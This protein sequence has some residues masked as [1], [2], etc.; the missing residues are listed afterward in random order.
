MEE[1]ET[2]ICYV[3]ASVLVYTVV[4]AEETFVHQV[5]AHSAID[6]SLL[7][8]EEIVVG[9]IL[10]V[11]SVESSQCVALFK[12]RWVQDV[13]LLLAVCSIIEWDEVELYL[14]ELIIS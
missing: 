14:S 9:L 5:L 2:E 10:V 7:G 4:N 8:I 1:G 12:C 11:F 3:S 13:M 6:S